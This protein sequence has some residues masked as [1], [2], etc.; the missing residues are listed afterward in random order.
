MLNPFDLLRI[1]DKCSVGYYKGLWFMECMSDGVRKPT[2]SKDTS[3]I[4]STIRYY[5]N[6]SLPKQAL[7]NLMIS[8]QSTEE[9]YMSFK[10]K[11]SL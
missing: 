9:T 2:I 1:N 7:D 10:E 11:Y 3:L 6:G 4:H 5:N 8:N